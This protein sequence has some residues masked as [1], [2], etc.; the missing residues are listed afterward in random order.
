MKPSSLSFVDVYTRFEVVRFVKNNDTTAALLALIVDY[1][2]PQ[3]LSTKC[4]R[5]DNS[6]KFERKLQRELNQYS[7]THKHTLPDKPQYNR[8]A[9][10]TLRLLREKVAALL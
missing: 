4:I 5:T 10:R 6:G 1:I 3:E 8:E 9:E 2:T 7:T